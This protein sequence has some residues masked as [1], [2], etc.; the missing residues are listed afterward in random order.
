MNYVWNL[1][2]DQVLEIYELGKSNGKKPGD[3][4]ED[5]ILVIAK[6][7]NL[8]P[9]G[10]TELTTEEYIKECESKGKKVLHIRNEGNNGS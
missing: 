5:E 6:K 8:K 4:I 2:L 3:S 7:Y 9:M 1:T 10:A